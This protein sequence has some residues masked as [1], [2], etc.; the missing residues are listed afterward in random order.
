MRGTRV[1]Q[2]SNKSKRSNGSIVC[3]GSRG[4]ASLLQ[5][6]IIDG[7]IKEDEVCYVS[8]LRNSRAKKLHGKF[9]NNGGAKVRHGMLSHLEKIFQMGESSDAAFMPR[10]V[11]ILSDAEH[12]GR[13]R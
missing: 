4:D 9:R 13:L 11:G 6:A 7:T 12:F 1:P 8:R 3:I 10:C 5:D 2:P